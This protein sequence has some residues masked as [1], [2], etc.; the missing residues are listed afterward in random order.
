VLKSALR[1]FI[2]NP[3][4]APKIA[5]HLPRIPKKLGKELI[6]FNDA[7]PTPGY[8]LYIQDEIRWKKVFVVE[9]IFATFCIGFAIV[10]CIKKGGGIQDGFAIAGTGIAYGSIMLGALQAVAHGR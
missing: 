1:H 10:W 6:L 2:E 4:H 3:D 8:G 7:K 5:H 9:A